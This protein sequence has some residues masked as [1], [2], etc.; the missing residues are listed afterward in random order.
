M[1]KNIIRHY[2]APL[3]ADFSPID[4]ITIINDYGKHLNNVNVF[5]QEFRLGSPTNQATAFKW[6]AGS[7]LFAEESPSKQ[8]THFG[9]DAGML[10]IQSTNFSNISTSTEKI[11]VLLFMVRV[12]MPSIINGN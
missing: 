4:A 8:A 2:N 11:P 12:V 5:T 6:T 1:A 10:G 7:Y 3:D 9:K